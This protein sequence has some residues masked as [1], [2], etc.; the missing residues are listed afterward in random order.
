[1]LMCVIRHDIFVQR[2]VVLKAT[3][4]PEHR[5]AV[6]R[7]ILAFNAACNYAAEVAFREGCVNKFRLQKL[8]YANLR[9][10]FALSAQ[11]AVRCI[12]KICE[13]YKRDKNIKPTFRELGAVPYDQRIL[14]W[15]GTE[16]VS[17]LTLEGRVVLPLYLGAFQ[18]ERLATGKRLGQA[19]ITL[20]DGNVYIAVVIEEAEPEPT[21]PVG[22]LGVDLGVVNIAVDSDGTTHTNQAV[23]NTR[24]RLHALTGALQARGT[25]SA[26]RHLRRL[27]GREARFHRNAN[28]IISKT[29]V[30]RAKDTG[31]GVALEDLKG[32]SARTTV[33]RS[34]RRRHKS[35]AFNQLRAFLTYKAA[36]AGVVLIAVDPRNTSRTCPACGHCTKE[37]RRTRDEFRCGSCGLA[38]PADHIAARNIAARAEVMRPIVP[39]NRPLHNGDAPGASP[40]L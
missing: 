11:M 22:F 15:K 17:L 9:S 5:R 4:S 23:E 14:S 33:R 25:R 13:A 31:R 18:R 34:Q 19:D 3:P 27:A 32:I 8:V 29:I 38:G 24:L 35:W 6:R 36:L 20:R 21:E 39:G 26:K 7:T 40:C 12:A 28:H 10:R 37:N 16:H 1:M 30:T 2:T